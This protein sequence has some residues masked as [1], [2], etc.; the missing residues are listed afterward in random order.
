MKS[1][2]LATLIAAGL[3]LA[4]T[5]G[6]SAAPASGAV[7]GETASHASLLQQVQHSRWRSRHWRERRCH[8]RHWS[9]GW[10]HRYCD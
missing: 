5:L 7:I 10:S 8:R 6:A 4:G 2:V 3:G 9:G 1:I